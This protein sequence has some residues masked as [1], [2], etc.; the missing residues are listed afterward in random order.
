MSADGVVNYVAQN[1]AGS[2]VNDV[3]DSLDL[4]DAWA[5][6]EELTLAW[7]TGASSASDGS[8]YMY[9]GKAFLSSYSETAGVNDVATYSCTFESSGDIAK[10]QIT[11]GTDTFTL[12]D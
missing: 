6:K 3:Q 7:T 1:Q 10:V 2:D 11:N 12:V 9:K 8:D 4:F 5:N